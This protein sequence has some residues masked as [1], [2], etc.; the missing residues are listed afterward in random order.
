ML[1][2]FY[3]LLLF[4]L[5]IY[6][7]ALVDPN[8][9]VISS[10]WWEVFREKMVELG[11]YRR[12]ISWIVYL[13]IIIL[14]F[15][16]NYL[17]IKKYKQFNSV[18]LAITTGI[19]LL[20]SYPFL[21]HDFFNYMFDARIA[22]FYHQNPYFHKALD[23]L[24][25]PWLRFLHWTHR[26]YP[27]GPTFLLITLIPSFL[28]F[29][30]FVLSFMFFKLTFV[31][32]YVLT[33]FFLNKLNKR[34]AIIFA[35]NPL[36]IIEG[37]VNS[38]NDLIGV[39]LGIIG[40]YLL[41]KNKSILARLFFILSL[42]IKYITFPIVFLMRKNARWNK[43]I[44]V[45]LMGVILYLSIKSEIQ[46]WY[47]LNLFIFIPFFVQSIN[48]LNV[49]FFGLLVSYYPYIRLGGWDKPEKIILKHWIIALSV[50][51]NAIYLFFLH[52]KN[53]EKKMAA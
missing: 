39:S 35:T 40:I 41:L 33:V 28:S 16:F 21:S 26:I 46:P 19:I 34:Y 49:F 18:K 47:F 29:G 24:T 15:V 8:L 23:F 27:Y 12:D 9:T 30:K 11:Y 51:L 50:V 2:I 53:R 17:F 45:F 13:I 36:V 5:T 52:L 25:D 48:R 7:Y 32:F 37:L 42:G 22:T 4:I 20:F 38:H 10:K 1:E 44:F 6:S 14:L 3:F 43:L 31:I